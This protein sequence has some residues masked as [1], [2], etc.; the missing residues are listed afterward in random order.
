LDGGGSE[1][2]LW[3]L[4]TQLPDDQFTTQIYL[5][6]RRGLYL[7]KLPASM[8]VHAFSDLA[9]HSR[10]PGAIHRAQVKHLASLLSQHKIDVCYDRTFHM[11]LVTSKACRIA[12]VPRVSV[13]V[14]PPSR[15]FAGSQER[16]RW[17]KYRALR[18]AYSDPRAT[19]IAVS[20]S[21]AS[22]AASFY[23]IPISCF[24]VVP[25]PVDV[26]AVQQ[27]AAEPTNLAPTNLAP[28]SRD[29]QALKIVVVGRMTAEK[30]HELV[31]QAVRQ[32]ESS[33]AS[34]FGHLQVSFVG[35]GPLR[36]ELERTVH[37]LQ[38][39]NRV[40]FCGF[41]DNPYPWIANA[42]LLCVPSSY[43]G[44]PNVALEAMSLRKPVIAT[45]CSD[46][47]V[48]LLGP[49]NQRGILLKDRSPDCLVAA[50][51]EHTQNAQAAHDRANSGHDWIVQHH[52]LP[53]WIDY[54]SQLLQTANRKN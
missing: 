41:Q 17:F 5:L 3:Q 9:F 8:C 21:V 47:L 46:S 39:E 7:E 1:R 28:T 14:S 10:I 33:E 45:R 31:L 49:A 37:E 27:A 2:Q 22:D 6:Y 13:V 20:H 40:Q 19:T 43:E 25:S 52:G 48:A 23:Q 50:L 36:A 26:A 11:T 30:G 35:D 4:A 16:F 53:N 12:N 38:L 54:M 29:E 44:L 32:W 18:K 34:S 42:D 51:R 24:H 15:D